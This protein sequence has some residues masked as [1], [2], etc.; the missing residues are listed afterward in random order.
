MNKVIS[1]RQHLSKTFPNIFAQD[2]K[3]QS[4]GPN[5]RAM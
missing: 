1:H 4:C 2:T 5:S 3:L